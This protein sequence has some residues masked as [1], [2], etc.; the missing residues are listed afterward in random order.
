MGRCTCHCISR[1]AVRSRLEF[2][3]E[4]K[5]STVGIPARWAA[6]SARGARR[7]CTPAYARGRSLLVASCRARAGA[8]ERSVQLG[9]PETAGPRTSPWRSVVGSMSSSTMV[10]TVMS[11]PRRSSVELPRGRATRSR[12]DAAGIWGSPWPLAS[13][14]TVPS[15]PAQPALRS[16]R[17]EPTF[18]AAATLH[19]DRV[20]PHGEQSHG[21]D[22]PIGGRF[23]AR[24]GRGRS[25]VVADPELRAA[26]RIR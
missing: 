23:H 12:Q 14:V 9:R 8:I 1:T 22:A 20:P 11:C 26:A 7:V 5:V 6:A 4:W 10:S 13:V 21:N 19:G 24:R 17:D 15:P 16:R 25:G 18:G 2:P 3:P